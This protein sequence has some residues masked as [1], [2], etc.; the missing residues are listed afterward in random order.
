[1]GKVTGFLEIDRAGPQVRSGRERIRH[2]KEFVCRWTKGRPEDQ[3]ARCMDCGIPYCHNGCPVNNQIPDWNDLVYRGD[4][5]E[6]RATCIRPTTSRSSPAASARRPA[7]RLHAQPREPAGH[8]QDDRARSPTRPGTRLD[9]A[10]AAEGADRQAHRRHRLRP[11]GPGRRAAARAR[12]PRRARLREARQGRRPA[13][14]RHP[15]FKMEKHHHRPPREADGGRGR[16]LPLRRQC[17][18]DQ[19]LR[20]PAQRVRR[21]ADGR[22]RRAPRDPPIPAAIST[23]CISRWTSCRSRTSA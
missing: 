1:M 8:H 3:A 9:Q 19:E 10:G 18:R 5:E 4:W 20:Q 17:R 16:H 6:A 23:A 14:L 15:D 21:G 7:R 2:Y 13:A 12:R 22:R 11:G